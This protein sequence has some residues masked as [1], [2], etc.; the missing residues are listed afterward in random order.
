MCM[1]WITKVMVLVCSAD[2]RS[3]CPGRLHH[4]NLGANAP[5]KKLRGKNFGK[6]R[7]DSEYYNSA[8]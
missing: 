7:G 8:F 1:I 4:I 2:L 3:L 5:R 6:L